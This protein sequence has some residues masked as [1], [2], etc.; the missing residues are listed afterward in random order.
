MAEPTD[1]D[2]FGFLSDLLAA[3]VVVGVGALVPIANS[4]P[5]ADDDASASIFVAVSAASSCLRLLPRPKESPRLI[6]VVIQCLLRKGPL[7]CCCVGTRKGKA[8]PD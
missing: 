2:E 1:P 6:T 4:V 5:D 7:A 8:M 3:A